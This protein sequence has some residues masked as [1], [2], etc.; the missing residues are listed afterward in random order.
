MS[1]R[2]DKEKVV[3][4]NFQELLGHIK[5]SEAWDKEVARDR[6]SEQIHYAM[7]R[8]GVS[9]SEL[10]GRLGKSRAYVTKILQGN[11]NFTIDTLVQ[12]GR[13]LGYRYT[14][15]FIPRHTWKPAPAIHLSAKVERLRTSTTLDNSGYVP[16]SLN[17][18]EDTD[19]R[20]PDRIA[21]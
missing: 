14:P 12:I 10:A 20:K 8:Q 21:G 5:D 9:K 2:K 15:L 4:T 11:V 3:V 1:T 16:V 18:E 19:A 17:P 13:A 7:I 6:I